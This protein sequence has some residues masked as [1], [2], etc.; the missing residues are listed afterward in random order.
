[1]NGK[2]RKFYTKNDYEYIASVG[3]SYGNTLSAQPSTYKVNIPKQLRLEPWDLYDMD[4]LQ[5]NAH[6]I[7]FE[8]VRPPFGRDINMDGEW[9]D[10]D[11][12][13]DDDEF[14]G[15]IDDG[16]MSDDDDEM[17]GIPHDDVVQ[18]RGNVRGRDDAG[19]DDDVVH[20]R[21]GERRQRHDDIPA[22]QHVRRHRNNK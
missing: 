21:R 11:D 4:Q 22:A 7:Q 13:D 9:W 5:R 6:G 2:V 20:R 17:G 15:P 8:F 1:M 12:D 10:D 19:M 16:D 18:R 14:I 3:N